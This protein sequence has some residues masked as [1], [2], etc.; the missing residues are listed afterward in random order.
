MTNPSFH[1]RTQAF[2]QDGQD[3]TNGKNECPSSYRRTITS[4]HNPVS[5]Y[6]WVRAELLRYSQAGL[7]ADGPLPPLGLLL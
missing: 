1:T 3:H 7:A 5:L 4:V 2:T 6:P